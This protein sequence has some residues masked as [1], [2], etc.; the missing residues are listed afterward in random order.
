MSPS[1]FTGARGSCSW[2]LGGGQQR[3]AAAA[4]RPYVVDARC[5]DNQGAGAPAPRQ[6]TERA[7]HPVPEE[8]RP[9]PRG[10]ATG[11]RMDD[12]GRGRHPPPQA[13]PRGHAPR[14][15]LPPRDAARVAAPPATVRGVGGHPRQEGQTDATPPQRRVE[16]RQTAQAHP[17]GPHPGLVAR[18]PERAGPATRARAV[19]TTTGTPGPG[20][21]T[22]KSCEAGAALGAGAAR[23]VVIVAGR[24]LFE[25]PLPVPPLSLATALGP[26]A[27][28]VPKPKVAGRCPP[29]PV[30]AP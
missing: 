14:P 26:V 12:G 8:L 18:R 21:G 16:H 10:A 22:T 5:A 30:G 4:T 13:T 9:A 19:E 27:R 11:E 1:G 25:Q 17:C 24:R 23:R 6:V 29:K 2:S 3:A 15:P 7:R 28:G 20:M